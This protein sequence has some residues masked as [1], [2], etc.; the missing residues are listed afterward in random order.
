MDEAERG[1]SGSGNGNGCDNG[2]GGGMVF[3]EVGF[4]FPVEVGVSGRTVGR[5]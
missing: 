5:G 3:E 2:C 1:P 4:G